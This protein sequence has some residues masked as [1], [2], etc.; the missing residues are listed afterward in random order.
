MI[1]IAFALALAA[2]TL[3]PA[4]GSPMEAR[5]TITALGMPVMLAKASSKGPAT[6]P[7]SERPIALSV[8][9]L[10]SLDASQVATEAAR[11]MVEQ[12]GLPQ[13]KADSFQALLAKAQTF[14]PGTSLA[15]SCG[16]AP[17]LTLS[18]G[19]DKLAMGDAQTALAFCS[20]WLSPSGNKE[21]RDGLGLP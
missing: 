16:S 18:H 12:A 5:A 20:I 8:E 2:L 3:A 10:R 19:A 9:P 7:W 4:R 17:T 15:G 13:E 1:K 11:R 6:G 14:E 21:L